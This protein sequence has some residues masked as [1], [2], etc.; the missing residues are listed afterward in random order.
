MVQW[1]H[2][3]ARQDWGRTIV[4]IGSPGPLI[5]TPNFPLSRVL[6]Q[7]CHPADQFEPRHSALL[8]WMVSWVKIDLL[9]LHRLPSQ[10]KF[11]H[12]FFSNKQICIGWLW[13]FKWR[14]AGRA[15][16]IRPSGY[17]QGSTGG[18]SGKI[19]C[20]VSVGRG[21]IGKLQKLT[22][23][24]EYLSKRRCWQEELT[25]AA[26]SWEGYQHNEEGL[27]LFCAT[28]LLLLGFR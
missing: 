21:F 18:R 6:T 19:S 1:S 26:I 3:P 13:Q 7:Y 28:S 17:D 14:V 2:K 4:V 24:S 15:D 20:P 12:Q 8:Q 23:L 25:A 5:F 16:L 27:C 11:G 22:N 9:R 10:S